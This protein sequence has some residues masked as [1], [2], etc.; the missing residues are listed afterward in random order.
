M[1]IQIPCSLLHVRTNT[2]LL[3]ARTSPPA[4][5]GC[6]LRFEQPG[7][8]DRSVD[9]HEIPRFPCRPQ[10]ILSSR[11]SLAEA[12]ASEWRELAT[13]C[14]RLQSS[15][16]SSR[17]VRWRLGDRINRFSSGQMGWA[18][19][20]HIV[21]VAVCSFVQHHSDMKAWLYE[22]KSMIQTPTL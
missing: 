8:I 18:R 11:P 22:R 13:Q 14:V 17:A 15:A 21:I 7:G 9:R 4:T 3:L 20:R 12:C 1:Q 2:A 19:V 10:A 6:R 16:V 5:S